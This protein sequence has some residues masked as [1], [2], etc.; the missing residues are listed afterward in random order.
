MRPLGGAGT[1]RRVAL[2]GRLLVGLAAVLAG[3]A[4]AP[5]GALADPGD[6]GQEDVSYAGASAGVP[7]SG[8]K[9]ESKLWFADGAW[10]GILFDTASGDFHIF[11]LHAGSQAWT[12]TGTV[13]D[14]RN[15]SVPDALWDAGT[16]KL[17]VASHVY[18]ESPASGYPS[19]CTASATT[20]RRSG[21]R[22]TRAS[23]RRSTRSAPR[24][25]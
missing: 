14:R 18:S 17:Y 19:T 16:G 10:W 11:R 21:T 15:N 6:A 2:P 5:A 8:S 13:V 25:S 4:V 22:S 12:D 3:F 24:R 20:P 23:R 1:V 9:P 7:P